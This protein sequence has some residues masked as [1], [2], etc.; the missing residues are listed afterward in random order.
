MK[1][2]RLILLG[3]DGMDFDHTR[4]MPDSLPNIKRLSEDGMVK[5]FKSVFPPDSIP[6]WI[7]C[8]TGKD[9]SEHGILE[10]VNYLAK[11]DERLKVD[12]SIFQGRTFWDIIGS[13][14]IEVCVINPFMAYPVWP[15][16]GVM[17][18]GPVFIDGN[19]QV[20]DP[21]W[22]EGVTVPKSL[23]GIVDFPTK[24][25]LGEFV[26]KTVSDTTEQAKFGL[27]LLEKKKPGL[28]FQTF[29][30]MDRI[31]HF[32]WR[33]CDKNDP[34]YP[35]KN[36]F[37]DVIDEFYILIDG[38]IGDFLKSIEPEDSLIV[39]SD[40]GHGMRCTHCFNINELLRQRGYL[41]STADGKW[42]SYQLIVERLKNSVL[43]FM[44]EHNLE[45]Y[46]RVVARFIPNAKNL[47]KGKHITEET[48][49]MAYASDFT[50]TNPFGG[51][52]INRELVHEYECFRSKLIKELKEVEYKG[53]PVFEWIKR[54]EEMFKGPFLDRYPDILFCLK[55]Q[56]GVNWSLH[57]KVFSV[58]PTHKK[59]SGGHKEYGVFF[60]NL[61]SVNYGE[62]KN[63]MMNNFF[64]T[65]L[66]LFE[67]NWN[68]IKKDEIYIR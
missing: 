61:P 12:T 57:T 3:I 49:N 65:V 66:D 42:I 38:I 54:R 20:S 59:I 18:N 36:P 10:S 40:H 11:K 41:Q 33:Y 51:I 2:R 48:K 47:K 50:G 16:N 13:S 19:I 44:N 35:G 22:V 4:S 52:C 14:G 39:F 9:P 31:Q 6:S 63:P 43:N 7:T 1:S 60:S 17:I 58:N 28:F 56:F 67:I 5:P 21:T 30:T 64:S 68:V 25:R 37:K 8:Y 34:T 29:L 24:K 23:G 32:L 45:D 46:I 15:V 26:K 27:S 62:N 53:N 55:E